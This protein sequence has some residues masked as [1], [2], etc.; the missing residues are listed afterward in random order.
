MD[1]S[2]AEAECPDLAER[3]D[4]GGHRC[5]GKHKLIIKAEGGGC[6]IIY[7]IKTGSFSL[8]HLITRCRCPPRGP[9]IL[10]MSKWMLSVNLPAQTPSLWVITLVRNLGFC[11]DSFCYSPPTRLSR[12]YC[13]NIP[14][15]LY[16]GFAWR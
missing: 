8:G 15:L 13:L 16:Y 11:K 1:P 3:K 9:S 14:S 4:L 5:C 6:L 10:N 7:Y 12:F 2:E